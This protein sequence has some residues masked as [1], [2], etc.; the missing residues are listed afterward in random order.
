MSKVININNTDPCDCG[1]QNNISLNSKN[2]GASFEHNVN[3]MEQ[4]FFGVAFSIFKEYLPLF[5]LVVD[6][7]YE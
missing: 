1:S 6:I 5:L 2:V 3:F 7:R 4:N